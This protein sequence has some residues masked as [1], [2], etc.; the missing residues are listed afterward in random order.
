MRPRG[1]GCATNGAPLGSERTYFMSSHAKKKRRKNCPLQHRPHKAIRAV[2]V[3]RCDRK[4]RR[5]KSRG[6]REARR[7]SDYL[8]LW[9][10]RR[11]LIGSRTSVFS[12]FRV[13]LYVWV[14]IECVGRRSSQSRKGKTFSGQESQTKRSTLKPSSLASVKVHY[15]RGQSAVS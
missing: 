2:G 13:C 11:R 4:L 12:V 7:Y 3:G 5:R 8:K 14:R 10:Y 15:L 1:F 9:S 6:E